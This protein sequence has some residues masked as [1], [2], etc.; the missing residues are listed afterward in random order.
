MHHADASSNAPAVNAKVPKG[1]V[2]RPRSWMM[3]ASIGKAV[4]AIAAPRNSDASIS[5]AFS[6]NRPSTLINH[7]HM[8]NASRNGTAMPASDTLIALR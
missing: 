8:A 3:R 1:L 2:A 5:L 4:I 7:G 6:E